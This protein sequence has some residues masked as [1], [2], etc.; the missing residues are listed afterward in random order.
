[1]IHLSYIYKLW[2]TIAKENKNITTS[3]VLLASKRLVQR[4]SDDEIQTSI[5]EYAKMVD[6]ISNDDAILYINS[7]ESTKKYKILLDLFMIVTLQGV[8]N[9]DVQLLFQNYQLD[10]NAM[11]MLGLNAKS[12]DVLKDI[13]KKVSSEFLYETLFLILDGSYESANILLNKH[14][15]KLK[16]ISFNK[17]SEVSLHKTFELFDVNFVVMKIDDEYVL[18][19]AESKDLQMFTYDNK[20]N[21]SLKERAKLF[22]QSSYEF[23]THLIRNHS[24]HH[25]DETSMIIVSNS[26]ESI[27]VDLEVVSDFF[28][29]A[30]TKDCLILKNTSELIDDV[31]PKIDKN[32]I[33]KLSAKNLFT[34]YGK[35]KVINK[36]VNFEI[37][38]RELIAIMGPSGAGKS[39][40]IKTLIN[41]SRVL[42]GELR[43]NDELIS[44]KFF[45]RIG[46]VPQDDV[47]IKELSVYDNLYYYYRLH[48]GREKSD[49][50]ID[51]LISGL[52]RDL[53]I[54]EIKNS[55]VF[56]KGKFTISGGQRKR[57]NIA[58]ELMKDVDLILMDE[59]TSGLSSQDSE[60]IIN[61]LKRIC[62]TGKIIIIIIHQP[63][64]SMYQKL[65]QVV[66]LNE[67]GK[68][69][70]TDTA[71]EV[72]RVFKLIKDEEVYFLDNQDNYDDVRC[73]TCQKT[74]PELL[75]EVQVNEKSKFWNLFSYLDSF[76]DKKL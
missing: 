31:K 46:Y 53:G 30:R 64:S 49:S 33:Y 54:L 15:S 14:E 8:N 23:D 63:S 58:L 44:E 71:M 18:L 1:M 4:Y 11:T 25:L 65:D 35:Y 41:Q 72:L 3:E 22:N 6:T 50:E 55:P 67:D 43:V 59:P 28:E 29:P 9:Q 37:N 76:T 39:T 51:I 38:E 40:L 45:H 60:N 16:F 68:N 57:L 61:E 69:I 52:L 21:L 70:Y 47:L 36:D 17:N 34:G 12:M 42:K 32:H 62:A 5:E 20:K 13:Y 56:S 74:D 24:I 26:E 19:N 75:L 10:T 48:F 7:L 73:P 66:L 2:L 27:Y